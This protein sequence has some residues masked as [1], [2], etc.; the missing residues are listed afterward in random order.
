MTTTATTL[1][2]RSVLGAL[3]RERL[4]DLGRVTGIALSDVRGGNKRDLAGLLSAAL[5]EPRLPEVLRELGR[6]E[7]RGV[8]RAND[9]N[10]DGRRLELL[11]RMLL[12][13]GHPLHAAALPLLQQFPQDSR[14]IPPARA[15]ELIHTALGV[16]FEETRKAV[17]QTVANWLRPA[18]AVDL[19]LRYTGG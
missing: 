11:E 15:Q 19:R 7:L 17:E 4:L 16:P 6:D 14:V 12:A 18:L 3:T 10:A 2:L 9:L 5:G 13:A 8:S 1:G